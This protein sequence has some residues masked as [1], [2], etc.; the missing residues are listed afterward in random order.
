[1]LLTSKQQIVLSVRPTQN[2]NQCCEIRSDSFV[3][4]DMIVMRVV[5]K[6]LSLADSWRTPP[7]DPKTAASKIKETCEVAA[8]DDGE[9]ASWHS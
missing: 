1:M 7:T 3:V 6:W 4:T 5:K 8:L 2:S 9:N